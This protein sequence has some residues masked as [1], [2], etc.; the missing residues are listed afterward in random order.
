MRQRVAAG[1]ELPIEQTRAELEAARVEQRIAQSENRAEE[2]ADQLRDLLGLGSDQPLELTDQDLPAPA[3]QP[4]NELVAQAVDT[5]PGLKQAEAEQRAR[6]E[7]LSG[8]R[9]SRWPIVSL[10]GTY[11]VLSKANNY[12]EFFNKFERNN[13]VAGLQAQIPL[14][15][16][17]V[18]PAVAMAEAD[19]NIAAVEVKTKRSQLEL[20][21][22]AQARTVRE[23]ELA[24][25]VAQLELQLAQQNQ[26]VVQAQFDQ[27]RATLRALEQAQLEENDK[28]LAFLDA[29]FGRQKAQLTLLEL[30]GQVG[31]VLEV[32]R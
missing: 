7:L 4:V 1:Y 17:H 21:V 9:G 8:T 25:R 20:Q 28:W 19:A 27:G 16:S 3:E 31:K 30:T 13:V 5:D 32:S 6:E 15:S 14:F 2:L 11:S 26:G 10:V 18:S 12:T 29:E 24:S 23:A 22:R